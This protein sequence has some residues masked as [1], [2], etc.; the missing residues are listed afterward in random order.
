MAW[1]GV[2]LIALLQFRVVWLGVLC[3]GL[4]WTGVVSFVGIAWIA[5][6]ALETVRSRAQALASTPKPALCPWDY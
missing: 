5:Y 4:D 1:S 2:D 6:A 3:L